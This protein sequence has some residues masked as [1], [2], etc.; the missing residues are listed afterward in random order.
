MTDKIIFWFF[1]IAVAYTYIGYGILISSLNLI[2]YLTKKKGK[3]EKSVYQP[4]VTLLIA[5]YNEE[6]W[7]DKKIINCK[8]INYPKDKLQVIWV[9]DGSDDQS[10]EKLLKYNDITILYEKDRRGKTSAINRAMKQV[11]SD[12]TVFSDANTLLNRN[13]IHAICKEFR[14]SKVGCVSG[15]KKIM[16][17]NNDHAVG[18]GEGL[19]WKY[20]SFLKKQESTIHSA[21]G[22]AGEL[23]AIRTLLFTE[24]PEDTIL[25][26]LQISMDIAKKG[27]QIKYS[28]KAFSFEMPSESIKEE[29][30]RKIRIAA[31]AFQF[32]KRNGSLLNIFR[33]GVLSF[34]FI[35][36][37]FIRWIV[38]PLAFPAIFLSNISLFDKPEV[39]NLY[40][41]ILYLQLIFYFLVIIGWLMNRY[42]IKWKFIFIPYYIL[43]MNFSIVK[44]FLRFAFKRQSSVWDKAKRKI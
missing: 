30:K 12:I 10:Y 13:C 22:A 38:V 28:S 11:K 43:F 24:I 19:Y 41:S 42:A 25:D 4:S 8:Q 5:A 14:S 15:E 36:H 23:F 39:L 21:M 20:E 33:Y 2:K 31:G 16:V 35:S 1:L 27:N 37:K 34:Q 40:N 26:D 7:I 18:F 29:S 6:K 32:L 44:G 9:I 17:Q 3:N